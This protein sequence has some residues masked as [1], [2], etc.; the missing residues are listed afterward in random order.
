MNEKKKKKSQGLYSRRLVRLDIYI[1]EGCHEPNLAVSVT[2][3]NRSRLH[4]VRFVPVTQGQSPV[5][6]DELFR[7]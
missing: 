5:M 3:R 2:L 1:L 6:R 7:V 4:E